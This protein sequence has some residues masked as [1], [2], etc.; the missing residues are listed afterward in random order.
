MRDEPT[1]TEAPDGQ[2][3][4]LGLHHHRVGR[5]HVGK[6]LRVDEGRYAARAAAGGYRCKA[7]AASKVPSA[8]NQWQSFC[9]CGVH[10][11]L[12]TRNWHERW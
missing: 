10:R 6:D 4:L 9:Y 5:P 2:E 11:R 3:V 7:A 12:R 1:V 8:L